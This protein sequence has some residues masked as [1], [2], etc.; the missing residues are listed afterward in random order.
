M[1]SI[2]IDDPIYPELLS[3]IYNPPEELFYKGDINFLQKTCISIVGTRKNSCYGEEMTRKIV[4]EL[5]VLDIAIVSGLAYG[6]DAIAHQAALDFGL[7][8]IAVLGGGIDNIYPQDNYKLAQEIIKKGLILSEYPGETPSLPAYFPQRNRIVSGLSI[9]T[10]VIEAPERS[11]TLITARLALEQ[12]REIFV[13]PGDTDRANSLGILRLLQKGGAYAIASGNDVI[14]VI[15]TRAAAKPRPQHPHSQHLHSA[16]P[17]GAVQR[18]HP[19]PQLNFNLPP[20]QQEILAIISKN[21]RLTLENLSKKSS[22][23]IE[24]LLTILSIL[25]VNNLIKTIDGKYSTR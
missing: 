17:S 18:K 4:E 3:Q 15:G 12:G 20:D 16:F 5:A 14:E 21:S 9:A 13:V 24:K 25:E 1:S 7:P 2:K 10:I 8:T 6:I 11:G 23:P 19:Q 22:L